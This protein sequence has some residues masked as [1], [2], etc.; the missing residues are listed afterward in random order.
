MPDSDKSDWDKLAGKQF[1]YNATP[2]ADDGTT[3]IH[4]L[5]SAG[6]RG[7]LNPEEPDAVI[8]EVSYVA[9]GEQGQ[10]KMSSS[11]GTLMQGVNVREH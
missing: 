5:Y 2:I 4:G 9:E 8:Y 6:E 1:P 11:L 3:A 10:E 7:Q